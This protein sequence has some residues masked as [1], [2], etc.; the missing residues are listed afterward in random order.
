MTTGFG[1]NRDAH[2]YCFIVIV[3]ERYVLLATQEKN[4][5]WILVHY[6]PGPDGTLYRRKQTIRPKN[7]GIKPARELTAFRQPAFRQLSTSFRAL[8]CA[9]N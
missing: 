4:K 2:W 1:N 5:I 7:S 9:S 3:C 6:I 8:P